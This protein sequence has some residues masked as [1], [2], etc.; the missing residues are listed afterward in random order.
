[1]SNDT[2]IAEPKT[3][4]PPT[5]P[6]AEAPVA[7]PPQ[8]PMRIVDKPTPIEDKRHYAT[9][10]EILSTDDVM[11]RDEYI[12]EWR[13]WVT[14][15]S[16][17]AEEAIKFQEESTGPAEKNSDILLVLL[18]AVRRDPG[19]PD[20]VEKFTPLFERNKLAAVKKKNL[21]A[22]KRLQRVALELNTLGADLK[23]S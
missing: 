11:V 10:D 9:S 6:Q 16:M 2:E 7:E 5:E 3:E 23:K 14:M 8:V 22:I 19:D 1:M 20:N 13:T 21:N 15:R 4:Q 12:P 18:C 17:T